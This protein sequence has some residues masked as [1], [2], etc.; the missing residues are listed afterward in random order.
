MKSH[1]RTQVINRPPGVPTHYLVAA[2]ASDNKVLEGIIG[3]ELGTE[4][5]LLVGEP[6]TH[7][8]SLGVPHLDVPEKISVTQC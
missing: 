3:V 5:H 7:L 6:A 8:A 1:F 4:G 2:G